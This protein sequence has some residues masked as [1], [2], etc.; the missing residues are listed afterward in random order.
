MAAKTKPWL[1]ICVFLLAANCIQQFVHGKSQVP[2][3]FIFGDSLSDSGNNNN[4]PTL[5]RANFR[6]YGID[7][8]KGPTGRFTNGRTAIDFISEFLGFKEP[9]PSYANT[10]GSN[11]L[12]G[13]NYASG[14][15]GIRR[16]SGKIGGANIDLEVQLRNHKVIYSM[17]AKKL[18][19]SEKAQQYLS[20]CLYYVNIGNNDYIY[21]YFYFPIYL[22]RLFYTPQQYA[23]SLIVRLSQYIKELVDELGARKV[24]LVGLVDIG[25]TPDAMSMHRTNGS[26]VEEMNNAAS[27]FNEELRS[28]VDQFNNNSSTD[29]KF[30]YLR[31]L[32]KSIF[33]GFPVANASCCPTLCF[34]NKTPCQNRTEY[35]FWDGLHST[36]A[37]NRI[38]A[39]RS[40]NNIMHLL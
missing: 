19:G 8:P 18:G 9:I 29:S 17:I 14:G 21:N 24:V 25:C 22:T 1:V 6:P 13:V 15:A 2:C 26:C 28:L 5:G 31:S 38:I 37:A 27:I 4:L 30:I 39:E 32:D 11:I 34:P 10:S 35:V 20:E 16:E 36:E 40:Y 3:L 12:K 23:N 7:F 33:L